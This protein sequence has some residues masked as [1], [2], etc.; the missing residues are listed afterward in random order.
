MAKS[1]IN[2]GELGGGGATHI[3]CATGVG[4]QNS[5]LSKSVVSSDGTFTLGNWSDQSVT[6]LKTCTA[7]VRTYDQTQGT[8]YT[9]NVGDV[10]TT[11]MVSN[12][13]RGTIMLIE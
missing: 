6:I 4:N 8:A 13:Y 10:I 5:L 2:F 11:P 1:Q 12:L 3:E 9:A 7:I